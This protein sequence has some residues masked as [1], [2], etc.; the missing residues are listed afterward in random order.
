MTTSV[1]IIA[2][3]EAKSIERCIKSIFAQTQKPDEIVLIAHNCTDET[4]TIAQSFPKVRVVSY[5]GPEGVPYARTKGFEEVSGDIVACI[6]GD[7]YA[8]RNWLKEVT[9]PLI[10][11]SNVSLVAGYVIITNSLWS[12]L[13]S[14]FQFIWNRK[15]AQQKINMFAWGS[16]FACR[17]KDYETVGGITPLIELKEKL[18]LHFWAEDLYISRALMQIGNMYVALNAKTYTTLPPWKLNWFTTPI[19]KWREDNRKVIK[20]FDAKK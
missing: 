10:K 1:L 18:Q 7:G 14:A 11:Y 4:V 20:Y 5:Q 3:N 15:I 19:W 12:R 13:T 6:D 2:H 16:N 8:H 9:K 17:K